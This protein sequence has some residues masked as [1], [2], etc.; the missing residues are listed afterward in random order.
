MSDAAGAAGQQSTRLL[1]SSAIVGLGTAL[2]RITGFLR[3]AAIAY[4]IGAGALAGTYSYA[5]ETP[6]MLYELLLGGVLTATLVPQFV[7]H[8]EREDDEAVSAIMTVSI[9]VLVAVSIAGV[10][11]APYIV[12]LFTLR[13]EGA[14]RAAQQEVATTLVRLFMPQI[15]FYGFTALA[16]ALLNAHR[17]FAAAAFAPM[18]NN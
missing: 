16:T 15:V 13:A 9:A 4:A 11:L 12:Q 5:N 3:V 8:V 1:R 6:N 10:L 2:S 14:S 7:R 17:R 18:L